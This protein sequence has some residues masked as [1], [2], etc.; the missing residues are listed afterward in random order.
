VPG[1]KLYASNRLEVLV[2][3]LA[4]HLRPALPFPLEGKTILV[5]SKGMERWVSMEL[6]R[7]HGICAN[8]RFPFPN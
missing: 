8:C 5:Q 6:A 2:E 7:R 1:L 3:K 4:E